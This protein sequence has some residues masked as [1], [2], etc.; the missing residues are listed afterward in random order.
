MPQVRI[1]YSGNLG[2]AFSARRFA[3]QIH[4]H[5]AAIALA[6][7]ASCKT[8]LVELTDVIIG[9]GSDRNG[10]IHVDLRILSGRTD[11]Q[12]R[13][14]GEAVMRSLREAVQKPDGVDLQLTVEVRDMA[15][16]H[17]HKVRLSA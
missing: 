10:M 14:L 11:Q 13:Q 7:P 8:R 15:R 17:Y 5:L 6:E 3:G 16:D 9:D 4:E 1:E 12:K 2:T